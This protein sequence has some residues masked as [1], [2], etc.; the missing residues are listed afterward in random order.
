M[1]AMATGTAMFNV[2]AL[3]MMNND[4]SSNHRTSWLMIAALVVFF[5]SSLFWLV[6]NYHRTGRPWWKLLSWEGSCSGGATGIEIMLSKKGLLPMACGIWAWTAAVAVILSMD[7]KYDHHAGDDEEADVAEY[8]IGTPHDPRVRLQQ[9]QRK[10][11][12]RVS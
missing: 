10:H 5:F 11:W 4:S 12:P 6:M 2:A 1:I 3:G 9:H 7:S 8:A